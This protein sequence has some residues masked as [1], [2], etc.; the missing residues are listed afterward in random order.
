MF[1]DGRVQEK[2]STNEVRVLSELAVKIDANYLRQ[3]IETMQRNIDGHPFLAIGTAKELIETIC[4]TILKE[5][6]VAIPDNASVP[7]LVKLTCKELHLTRK[8][9]DDT[10]KA[11]DTIKTLLSNLASVASG[12]AMLRNPY[13]TGHGKHAKAR[14]LQ[15]RHARLAVGA[16]ATLA[17]F[18]WETHE[19]RMV[20]SSL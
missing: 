8:D 3:Q 10:A 4:K 16:S 13:G 20:R 14:G 17:T 11:A 6:D 1:V 2:V 5:R 15:P 7:Q 9:V 12:L 19:E 18:L